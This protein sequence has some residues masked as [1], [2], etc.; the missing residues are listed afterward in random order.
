MTIT[1]SYILVVIIWGS[2]WIAIT[3]QYGVVSDELSVSYRFFIASLC[4][5]LLNLIKKE[6]IGIDPANYPMIILS[7]SSMFCFNYLFTYY[8]MHSVVSGLA[9]I[10]FSLMVVC[11]A[12]FE[13]LFFGRIIE[14]RIIIA[15]II[16]IIGLFLIF[17]LE[18]QNQ[19]NAE[20]TFI[21]IIWLLIAVIIS[22]LGNMT[23]IVNINR[24]IPIITANAHAMLWG[25]II[26]FLLALIL[27]KPIVFSSD[28]SYVISLL[29]LSVAA[30]AITF[31][32]YLMLIKEIGSTRTAYTTLLF[33]VVALFISTI[34]GEYA[35]TIYSF[36]GVLLILF[37]TWLALPKKIT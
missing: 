28:P 36:T 12:F 3:Y 21:G 34:I 11:N 7:G 5:F 9:A 30:S 24:G 4:L 32:C 14:K 23:A 22:S 20:D 35:W 29:F 19:I 8:G 27:N 16:G 26:S 2:S 13:R 33:P 1:L 31:G 17:F 37:G 18:I 25:S 6:R 15:T 10:L